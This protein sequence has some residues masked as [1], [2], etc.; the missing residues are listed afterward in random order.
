MFGSVF[1]VF[2]HRA[3]FVLWLGLSVW[4]AVSGPFGTYQSVTLAERLSYWPFLIWLGITVAVAVRRNG[5][6]WRAW[7]VDSAILALL[8]C[9]PAA[10][11]LAAMQSVPGDGI[12]PRDLGQA[13]LAVFLTAFGLYAASERGSEERC[14]DP[15]GDPPLLHR[16][17]SGIRGRILRLSSSNHYVKVVTEHGTADLLMRF[18]DAIA[19]LDGVEG[20][21]VH[22][23]HWVAR[24][25]VTGLKRRN[26]R[27]FLLT[28]DGAEVPVSRSHLPAVEAWGRLPR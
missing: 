21:R 14:R 13:A 10:W 16:V 25:A 20:L 4:F 1:F 17:P 15:S 28:E 27:L 12:S 19:E 23:S 2:R 22:R 3:G 26:A 5:K 9:V 8:L 11:M 18:A 6:G 24:A 7:L